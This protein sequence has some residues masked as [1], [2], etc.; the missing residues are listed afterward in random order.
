MC[1][2]VLF[3][4]NMENK[5]SNCAIPIMWKWQKE[6]ILLF[7]LFTGAHHSFSIS[8][9]HLEQVLE[10]GEESS[11]IVGTELELE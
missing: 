8:C 6:C 1:D 2:K 4:K 10:A 11:E 7:Q 9:K 3:I 5:L